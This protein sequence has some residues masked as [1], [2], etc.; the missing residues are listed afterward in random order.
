MCDWDDWVE[1]SATDFK[2]LL[3]AAEAEKK[4][5]Q[6][7]VVSGPQKPIQR[8]E[9]KLLQRTGASAVPPTAANPVSAASAAMADDDESRDSKAL[10]TNSVPPTP[11]SSASN[12]GTDP[13]VKF[14]TTAMLGH[15]GGTVRTITGNRFL[16]STGAAI[17]GTSSG[18]SSAVCSIP[19]SAP[20]ALPAIGNRSGL[21]VRLKG[22]RVW[23]YIDWELSSI[24]SAPDRYAQ[25]AVRA[26]LLMDRTPAV[27]NVIVYSDAT[28]PS[29]DQN[30][31]TASF[32]IGTQYQVGNNMSPATKQRFKILKDHVWEGKEWESMGAPSG[33]GSILGHRAERFDWYFPLDVVQLYSG[34]AAVDYIQNQLYFVFGA[35]T[36]GTDVTMA[37]KYATCVYFEDSPTTNI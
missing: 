29:T 4:R 33:I 30:A 37:F 15:G 11:S 35:D 25:R 19:Q 12:G 22:V 23:G 20:G 7:A 16:G 32:G 17:P 18:A 27:P 28:L 34:S 21:A 36:P 31:V 26:I 14:L 1:V 2:A 8:T 3:A 6:N 13:I 24:T 10:S 9:S 5:Q